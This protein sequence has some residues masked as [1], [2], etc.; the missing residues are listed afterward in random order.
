MWSGR[1]AASVS[2]EELSDCRHLWHKCKN[3]L[4]CV[5]CLVTCHKICTVGSV[6]ALADC[7]ESTE[8]DT[9]FVTWIRW[10]WRWQLC[11]WSQG[12]TNT[13]Q[14]L[15]KT[16]ARGLEVAKFTGV[17]GVSVLVIPTKAEALV[18]EGG[19]GPTCW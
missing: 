5:L 13:A 10:E 7:T 19:G 14:S 2:S 6:G 15:E 8:E 12:S 18:K 9:I 11:L 17:M 3:A 1:H 16:P 4:I